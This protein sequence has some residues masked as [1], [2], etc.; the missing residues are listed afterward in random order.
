MI[1]SC[2]SCLFKLK[3]RS[4]LKLSADKLTLTF[5]NHPGQTPT[6]VMDQ[7]LL[8]TP[9]KE[10]NTTFTLLKIHV[11][12]M[13]HNQAHDNVKERNTWTY[14]HIYT[15]THTHVTLINRIIYLVPCWS[16]Y[17]LRRNSL[18][19]LLKE[20]EEE[21]PVTVEFSEYKTLDLGSKLRTVWCSFSIVASEISGIPS[22]I[23]VDLT[24]Y[25]KE[26]I[27]FGRECRVLEWKHKKT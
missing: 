10:K 2:V 4:L 24:V 13:K 25:L 3:S 8:W 1:A 12:I 27:E 11:D 22:I 18:S 17:V 16:W 7:F 5:S 21:E 19:F 14:T 26:V 20:A 23:I 15:R 6:H 9:G